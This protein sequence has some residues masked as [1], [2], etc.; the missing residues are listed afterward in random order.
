MRTLLPLAVVSG[1]GGRE[2]PDE[3]TR[4]RNGSSDLVHRHV[5][6]C[7]IPPLAGPTA[8]DLPTLGASP[9]R[10][11]CDQGAYAPRSP[12]RLPTTFPPLM[13]WTGSSQR[14]TSSILPTVS[15]SGRLPSCIRKM[16]ASAMAP[17]ASVPSSVE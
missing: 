13:T 16:A 10:G 9:R 17:T 2:P 15:A 4:S 6:G 3:S 14:L 5:V 12:V 1:E 11:L 8:D 7:V